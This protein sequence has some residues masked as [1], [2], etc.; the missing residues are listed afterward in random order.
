MMMQ[1]EHTSKWSS[2]LS[3]ATTGSL[4]CVSNV[5][6][7]STSCTT[8]SLGWKEPGRGL[9]YR[10]SVCPQGTLECPHHHTCSE[11]HSY[12]VTGLLPSQN[13]TIMVD[14]LGPSNGSSSQRSRYNTII[15]ATKTLSEFTARSMQW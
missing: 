1:I 11:C 8:A 15:A 9:S 4:L 10:I 12:T 14:T 6:A 2:V 13:Y 3:S 7:H 5:V